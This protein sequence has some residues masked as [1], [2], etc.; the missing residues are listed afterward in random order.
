MTKTKNKISLTINDNPHTVDAAR[1]LRENLS[2][3]VMVAKFLPGIPCILWGTF[4]GILGLGPDGPVVPLDWRLAGL[5]FFVGGAGV[6]YPFSVISRRGP[7][8][9][10]I[11][12]CA[13]APL[14]AW[15]IAMIKYPKSWAPTNDIGAI[16]PIA[17]M[18]LL[19]LL[20][21]AEL[22][23]TGRYR[24]QNQAEKIDD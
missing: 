12:G 20:S 17:I 8:N 1:K 6:C 16:I 23:L 13:T 5:C 22:V 9:W 3:I 4:I 2:R 11:V 21:L 19:P 15:I 24:P 18:L 7:A 14:F 10:L